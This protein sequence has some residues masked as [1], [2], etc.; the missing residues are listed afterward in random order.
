MKAEDWGKL[1][2]FAGGVLFGTAGISI[3]KSQDMKKAYTQCTAAVLRGKD[4]IMKCGTMIREN[5]GDIHADAV[6][7]NEKRYAE[8]EKKEIEKARQMVEEAQ[9]KIDQYEKAKDRKAEDKK[10][11]EK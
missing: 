8:A 11:E 6:D 10:E 4:S 5:C 9:A 3:L 2:L 1:G 7:I